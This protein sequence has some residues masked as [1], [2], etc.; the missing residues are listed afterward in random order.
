MSDDFDAIW[1]EVQFQQARR[2]ADDLAALRA[3]PDEYHSNK[4][5]R[6]PAC[7]WCTSP[8]QA[9]LYELY[10]DG[11]HDV[12]CQRCGHDFRVVVE[13][14]FTFLSPAGVPDVG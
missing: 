8:A 12:S 2:S 1:A 13:A 14:C 4:A 7:G 6:C 9:D 11:G 5:I 10:A 3:D